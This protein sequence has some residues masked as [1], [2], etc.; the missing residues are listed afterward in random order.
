MGFAMG[1]A[2]TGYFLRKHFQEQLVLLQG[3]SDTSSSDAA[4]TASSS[5]TNLRGSPRAGLRSDPSIV[6]THSM[7][8]ATSNVLSWHSAGLL[9]DIVTQMWPHIRVAVNGILKTT[10]EPMF[11]TML[12]GPL[13]SLT[14]TALDV[15]SVPLRLD[16]V[17]VHDYRDA[18]IQI[19]M[20]VIWDA[21]VHIH[22]RADYVGT[23]GVQ[24][25]QLR[26]RLAVW[27]QPLTNAL[28]IVS[29][30]QYAFVNPPTVALDFTGLAQV[31]DSRMLKKSIDAVLA[32]V[33]QSMIVLPQRMMYKLDITNPSLFLEMYHPPVGVLR[34]T[35]LNGNRFPIE[36]RQFR[37]A[38]VPDV[39]TV[40]QV[41]DQKWTSTVCRDQVD[42]T[43]NQAVDLIVYDLEQVVHVHCWDQ[44]GG[45]LDPD[46]DLGSAE[47]T[48]R[49]LLL[50]KGHRHTLML[51][52]ETHQC[53]G[54]SVTLHCDLSGFTNTQLDSWKDPCRINILNDAHCLVGLVTIL[55]IQAQHIPGPEAA[56]CVRVQY[57]TCEFVTPVI[58]P[59]VGIDAVNPVYDSVFTIPLT[60]ALAAQLMHAQPP[61][62]QPPAIQLH[63][64]NGGRAIASTKVTY[65]SLL[66][67]PNHTLTETRMVLPPDSHNDNG[68]QLQFRIALQGLDRTGT[69]F[70]SNP[71]TAVTQ[72]VS[73]PSTP[74][75]AVLI[76]TSTTTGNTSPRLSDDDGE[77]VE[78]SDALVVEGDQHRADT[79]AALVEEEDMPF[80][81]ALHPPAQLMLRITI[82]KGMGFHKS[83]RRILGRRDIPDVYCQVRY[84]SSPQVWRTNTIQDSVTPEWHESKDVPWIDAHQMIQVDVWD[85]NKRGGDD[86]LGQARTAV[87]QVL[88]APQGRTDVELFLPHQQPTGCY[89][90]IQ[91]ETLE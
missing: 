50:T 57:G 25:L 63:L 55:I 48:I 80:E 27:L 52:N 45:P 24:S 41:G 28:P 2:V 34:L 69:T 18:C 32:S 7:K 19:D 36:Q 74:V 86:F 76:T 78:K 83:Q 49:E 11:A 88:L 58:S 39:Y 54:A 65:A 1:A 31:A 46:D 9:S 62:T 14:F 35:L 44:D 30:V 60:P 43:W 3:S 12:P 79:A 4:T 67:A 68:T 5:P 15:G 61:H 87:S 29:A 59:A 20:D 85:A 17:R 40:I 91:C 37:T 33:L 81:Q 84:G 10:I 21:H 72:P 71:V 47:I 70:K 42:P 8:N 53:N 6:L 73:T 26:G 22:L 77:L 13:A 90:T 82:V 56:S 51:Q 64:I 89:I 75:A 66:A 38:D 16:N 23:L